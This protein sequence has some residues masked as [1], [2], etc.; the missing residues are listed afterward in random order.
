MIKTHFG[1]GDCRTVDANLRLRLNRFFRCYFYL[2]RAQSHYGQNCAA[3][4]VP[5][6]QHFINRRLQSTGVTE[7]LPPPSPAW[8]DTLLFSKTAPISSVVPCGTNG[9]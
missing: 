7:P 2:P 8:D 9:I 4:I 6:G 3:L 1:Q 5:Q